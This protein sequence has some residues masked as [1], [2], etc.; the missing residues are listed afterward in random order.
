LGGFLFIF[1][2]GTIPLFSARAAMAGRGTPRGRVAHNSFNN[3]P[4][5]VL[6]YFYYRQLLLSKVG[7][8][9]CNWTTTKGQPPRRPDWPQIA[10]GCALMMEGGERLLYFIPPPL[11]LPLSLIP[12]LPRIPS[13]S[14]FQPILATP[15]PQ[16]A[17]RSPL[18]S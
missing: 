1:L 14:H 11:L 2:G 12:T 3:K 13:C 9:G 15:N 5:V 8:A 18:P 4:F 10:Q 7:R 16:C 6:S 17:P